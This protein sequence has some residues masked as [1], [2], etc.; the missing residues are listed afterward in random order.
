[1][2]RL[3]HCRY[4]GKFSIN[5]RI[6]NKL[7]RTC[8]YTIQSDSLLLKRYGL[9]LGRASI[10]LNNKRL[11]R[12]LTSTHHGDTLRSLCENIIYYTKEDRMYNNW[13]IEFTDIDSTKVSISSED[14]QVEVDSIMYQPV[15]DQV[16]EVV[17]NMSLTGEYQLNTE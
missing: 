6:Y 3:K 16:F 5:D 12:E 11:D 1:M 15:D 4:P 7:T 9:S 13:H 8:K 10:I 17:I 2:H 14:L